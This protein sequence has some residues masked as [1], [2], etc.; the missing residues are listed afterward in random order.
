MK[1]ILEKIVNNRK[2]Q[3]DKEKHSLPLKQIR[4]KVDEIIESGYKPAD[5]LHTRKLKNPF[6]IAEVKKASPSKGIIREDFNLD[7]IARAYKSS[8]HVNAISVLTE[9][10][11]FSGSYDYIKK[12]KDAANKPVLMKDFIFDEYQI[13]RGF[14]EGA[15]A[16]LLIAD[17]LEDF[18]I[19]ILARLAFDLNMKILF[20]AHSS[21][22]YRR[23]LNFDFKIIGINNRDLK[24]FVT[25]IQNTIKIIDSE[26]KPEG[27]IIISESGINSKDDIRILRGSGADGFLIGE[28]FMKQKH[29]EQAIADLFGE[30]DETSC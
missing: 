3:L 11:F 8:P 4:R 2:L 7:D 30:S 28:R 22:E 20:E 26:G 27:R 10:D 24:T 1:T 25:D 12:I 14:I 18:Q 29:I 13:Y 9:P 15:S 23:A 21:A 19:K 16:I 6:L 5:F 17:V